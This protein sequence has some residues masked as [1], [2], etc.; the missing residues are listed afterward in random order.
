MHPLWERTIKDYQKTTN[1]ELEGNWENESYKLN[2]F[3]SGTQIVAFI[4]QVKVSDD[5]QN[6]WHEN[7]LKFI[8]GE[9]SNKGIY[10]MGNKTPVPSNFIVNKFGFL[11]I[12]LITS[13]EKFS[14]E[15]VK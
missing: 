3:Q 5:R 8:F 4:N 9:E 6:F 2:I 12:E 10:L 15:R 7:N 1:N 11:E 13:G 14:F